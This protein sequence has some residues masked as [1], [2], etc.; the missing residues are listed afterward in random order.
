MKT[1]DHPDLLLALGTLPVLAAIPAGGTASS[2]PARRPSSRRP[3]W[4]VGLTSASRLSAWPYYGYYPQPY[5][6]YYPYAYYPPTTRRRSWCQQQPPVYVE[7]PAPGPQQQA[8]A[9]YWYYCADSRA[10]YP[11]VKECPA[12][13]QRVAP[14]PVDATEA[15]ATSCVALAAAA[16]WRLRQHAERPRRDGAAGHRQEFRP[17]PRRR[18]GMPPVREQPGR[19]HAPT[20]PRRTAA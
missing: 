19:R 3:R 14:Q 9:G 18:H 8:P 6:P 12:G 17:V 4:V 5:Y 2:R 11:Y 1:T 16:P 15:R 10:Y 20:A 13:W 7:Q